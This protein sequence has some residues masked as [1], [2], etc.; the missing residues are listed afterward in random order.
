MANLFAT[1]GALAPRV[2]A[3]AVAL[4]APKGAARGKAASRPPARAQRAQRPAGKPPAARSR[5]TFNPIE[6]PLN[7]TQIQRIAKA[8]AQGTLNAE[9]QPLKA[10]QQ[11]IRANELGASE[12]YG[13][14][15]GQANNLLGQ[16]GTAQQASAKT[17]ENQ[18]ADSAL[19]AGKAIETSGQNASTLTGGYIAPELRA[20]LNAEANRSVAAGA[21]GNTFAQNSAQSGENLLSGLRGAAALRATEGQG[22]L[23]DT[24]QKEAGQVRSRE[25]AAV[26]KLG[27]FQAKVESE[28][29]QKNLTDNA[30]QQGLG[31]KTQ[32]LQQK[33]AETR[34]RVGATVRGQNLASSRNR[35]NVKEREWATKANL[36]YKETH[37]TGKSTNAPKA[38][39]PKE[40]RSYMAKLSTA[41]QI[42]R[43]I[44]GSK[45]KDPAAQKTAREELAKKGASG[46]VISA[47]LN[48][49]AY[50]R[51]G[52]QD[53][54]TAEAYG[55]TNTMRPAWFRTH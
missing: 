51:L 25:G 37:P 10:Q 31:L 46:D 29:G 50:G 9:L 47:A 2:S 27:P 4:G 49:V 1:Q 33:G 22:K 7:E 6:G 11:E 19:Q 8:Q 40:G 41:E 43:T 12:R 15:A 44:L 34:E 36:T 5:T 13:Q 52:P 48:L 26:A 20:E 53:R 32:T 54:R 23:T 18:A 38:P 35:E 17:F 28:L 21:A 39:S 55:L 30:V 42:A 14:Y 16:L 24:F 45:T 3:A